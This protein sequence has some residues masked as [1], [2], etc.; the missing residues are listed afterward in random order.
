MTDFGD[1]ASAVIH[2]PETCGMVWDIGFLA[3]PWYGIGWDGMRPLGPIPLRDG[4][5][6]CPG[7][8]HGINY[9][10][11]SVTHIRLSVTEM[12]CYIRVGYLMWGRN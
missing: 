9:M 1:I 7:I 3:I 6:N 11:F 8:S 10:R 12:I 2:G 5:G 4:M